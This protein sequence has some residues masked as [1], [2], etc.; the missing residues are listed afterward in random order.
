MA[1]AELRSADWPC[2]NLSFGLIEMQDE[3]A[4]R[5]AVRAMQGDARKHRQ[6]ARGD[7]PGWGPTVGPVAAERVVGLAGEHGSVALV[8]QGRAR[9]LVRQQR[10]G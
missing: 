9:T 10:G 2:F 1:H 7:H 6:Y 8:G 4:Q 3:P 5:S